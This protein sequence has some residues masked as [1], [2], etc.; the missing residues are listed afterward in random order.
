MVFVFVVILE[1]IGTM[2]FLIPLFDYDPLI[3]FGSGLEEFLDSWCNLILQEDIQIP[4]FIQWIRKFLQVQV[5]MEW[6]DLT[7]STD[8]G[9]P[10]VKEDRRWSSRGIWKFSW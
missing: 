3:S 6:K 10:F 1:V 9:F 2:V 7:T 4:L 8:H 5:G